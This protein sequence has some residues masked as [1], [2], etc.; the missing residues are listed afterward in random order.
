MQRS[1]LT[2]R[3]GE[4]MS[5]HADGGPPRVLLYCF[6]FA[7]G[8]ARTY[9]NWQSLVPAEVLVRPIELPGRGRC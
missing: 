4:A 2:E 6:P 1:T 3:Q 9:A 8:S 5:Q 7:G